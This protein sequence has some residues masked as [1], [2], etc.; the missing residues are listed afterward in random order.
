MIKEYLEDHGLSSRVFLS[1]QLCE[2]LCDEG[3][4]LKIDDRIFKHVNSDNIYE[5][6]NEVFA[7]E[8]NNKII[9]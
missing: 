5:I 3:P 1:G 4:I 6:L 2:G 8:E 9:P 7:E